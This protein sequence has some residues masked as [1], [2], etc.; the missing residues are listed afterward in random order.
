M[1][2]VILN[3]ST[4]PLDPITQSTYSSSIN[5]CYLYLSGKLLALSQTNHSPAIG[6][7]TV[8]YHV[9]THV[10]KLVILSDSHLLLHS[11]LMLFI[12]LY[13]NIYY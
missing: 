10:V 8:Y 9:G 13:Y 5:N 2:F 12:Y 6:K 1:E 3:S 7:L 11:H 4:R